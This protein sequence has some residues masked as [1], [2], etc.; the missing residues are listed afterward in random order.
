MVYGGSIQALTEAADCFD[1]GNREAGR[2]KIERAR[3]FVTHLY[4]TLDSEQGGEVAERLGT[5]YVFI[6]ERLQV[7]QAT[8]DS[9]ILRDLAEILSNLQ[10]GWQTL[11]E[12][13]GKLGNNNVPPTA[14]G[15][16]RLTIV[17]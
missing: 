8:G 5:L 7:S 9:A 15:S 6:L 14:S 1:S 16:N 2:E 13:S 10:S 12:T 11:Q 17:G 3:K 4:T